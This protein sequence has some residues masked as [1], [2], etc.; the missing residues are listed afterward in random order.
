MRSLKTWIV[1]LMLGAVPMG[2][3]RSNRNSR[4][5]RTR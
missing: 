4:R 3:P 1:V 2:Q 5:A